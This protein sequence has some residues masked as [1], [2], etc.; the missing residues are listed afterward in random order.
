[1][2]ESGSG[3]IVGSPQSAVYLKPETRNQSLETSSSGS[4]KN[5]NSIT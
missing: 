1:M 4:G 2:G 5:S 3:S